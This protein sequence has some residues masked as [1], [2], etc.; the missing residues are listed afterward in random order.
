MVGTMASICEV[1]SPAA[2]LAAADSFT[3]SSYTGNVWVSTSKWGMRHSFMCW[4][5]S[6]KPAC[7]S[8][9]ED[10]KQKDSV[11]EPLSSNINR[12]LK[13]T[14]DQTEAFSTDTYDCSPGIQIS[15]STISQG[16][17]L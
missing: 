8:P 4:K 17:Q 13:V 3:V 11:H 7:L 5:A 9:D 10:N 15:E 1:T 6:V 2:A 16:I 12:A 14:L